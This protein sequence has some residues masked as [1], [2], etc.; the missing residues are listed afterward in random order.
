MLTRTTLLPTLLF[1]LGTAARAVKA[2]QTIFEETC[3][4]RVLDLQWTVDDLSYSASYITPSPSSEQ[5][6]WGYVG[7]TLSSTAVPYTA[8][9]VAAST[10]GFDGQQDYSC[11]LS[12]GAPEGASVKFKYDKEGGKLV[13]EEVVLCSEQEGQT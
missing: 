11:T 6:A 9:C 1:S 5:S 4:N 13:V 3:W 2:R 7:F 12:E 8:D 10:V